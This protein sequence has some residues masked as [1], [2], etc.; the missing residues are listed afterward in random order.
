LPPAKTFDFGGTDKV[1]SNPITEQPQLAKRSI[2]CSIARDGHDLKI[3][4]MHMSP[5]AQDE[6][7]EEPLF[8]TALFEKFDLKVPNQRERA[9]STI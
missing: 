1:T 9:R 6:E 2:T 4:S 5:N 7:R 3:T 8:Y